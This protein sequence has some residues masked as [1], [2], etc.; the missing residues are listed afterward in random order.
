[1]SDERLSSLDRCHIEPSVIAK[2]HHSVRP[3]TGH[4]N[5]RRPDTIVVALQLGNAI[6]KAG[7]VHIDGPV[8]VIG[9]DG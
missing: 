6:S 4:H 1:M 8:F 2:S 9:P 3:P 7:N 5:R